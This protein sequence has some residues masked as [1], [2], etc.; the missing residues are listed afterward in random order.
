MITIHKYEIQNIDDKF[1]L[2]LPAGAVFLSVQA[3][4]NRPQM[5]MLV[6]DQAEKTAIQFAVRGTGH[7][8]SNLND[9]SWKYLGTFQL[10]DG[11]HVFHL[12]AQHAPIV[13]AGLTFNAKDEQG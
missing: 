4:Q 5:W 2:Q 9:G 6:D 12:F 10:N 11:R 3:Q 13:V 7:D 1:E 8:C